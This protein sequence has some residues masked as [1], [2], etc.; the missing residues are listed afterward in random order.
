MFVVL[1][2]AFIISPFKHCVMF[3]TS[4]RQVNLLYTF[5]ALEGVRGGRKVYTGSSRT[6]LL[7]VI[8]GLSYRYH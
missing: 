7:P 4:L 2:V 6:F 5:W 8:G 3:R 1:H